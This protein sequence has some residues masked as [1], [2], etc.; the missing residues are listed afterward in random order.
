MRGNARR[1]ND[2]IRVRIQVERFVDRLIRTLDR[3][4]AVTDELEDTDIDDDD[5]LEPSL[6]STNDFDQRRG[7][8]RYDLHMPDGEQD[9]SCRPSCRCKKCSCVQCGC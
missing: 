2:I 9:G 4:D 5:I 6:G 3:I 1:L 7:W 8:R